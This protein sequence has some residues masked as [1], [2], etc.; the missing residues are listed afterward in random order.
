MFFLAYS[1]VLMLHLDSVSLV[2][3]YKGMQVEMMNN[4]IFAAEV[5]FM[6]ERM[7]ISIVKTMSIALALLRISRIRAAQKRGHEQRRLIAIKALTLGSCILAWLLDLG[8]NKK[9]SINTPASCSGRVFWYFFRTS[10]LVCHK[11]C[12]SR[13]RHF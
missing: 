1:D 7:E 9:M 3:I 10:S 6:H 4:S 5:L 11:H 2:L 13:Q 12:S 8:T